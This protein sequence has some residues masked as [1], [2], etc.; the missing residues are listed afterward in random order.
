MYTPLDPEF[1]PKNLKNRIHF[2]GGAENDV[3][4]S[5]REDVTPEFYKI[6]GYD[7]PMDELDNLEAEP[8]SPKFEKISNTI[9]NLINTTE[10]CDFTSTN[11]VAK[12][13]EK[14]LRGFKKCTVPIFESFSDNHTR[15]FDNWV[16]SSRKCDYIDEFRNLNLHGLSNIDEIKW[17]IYPKC[18][19]EN[20]HVTLGVGH[21][22]QAELKLKKHQPNTKFYAVDPMIAINYDLVTEQLNGS[23]FA[24]ALA[25]ETRMQNFTVKEKT[26]YV[27]K[28]VATLD[29]GYFFENLLV[30]PKI[31]TLFLDIE[32]GENYF[33]EYFEK[34]GKFDEIG[35]QICQFNIEFHN[36]KYEYQDR[37]YAFLGKIIDDERNE[38]QYL[39]CSGFINNSSSAIENYVNSGRMKLG[40]GRVTINFSMDCES[41]IERVK[42]NETFENELKNPV[43]FIRN[44]YT[45]YEFQEMLLT[46]IYHPSNT[47]CY[48]IDQKSEKTGIFENLAQLSRCLP[49]IILNPITYDF[50]SDGYFQDRANFKCLELI[51][52]RKWEHVIFLQNNDLVIK[53][54]EELAE[55]SEILKAKSL[56]AVQEPFEDRW[57]HEADWTPK[58]LKLFKN[59]SKV[60]REILEKPLRIWKGFNQVIL[61]RIFVESIFEMLDLEGILELFNQKEMYGVD[62]MLVQTLYRNN[63]GLAGQ[64]TSSNLNTTIEDRITRWS[65]W[66]YQPSGYNEMCRSKL[67]R[68][69]ICIMGVEY[70]AD[71]RESSFVIA[72]KILEDFD[73]APLFCIREVFRERKNIYKKEEIWRKGTSKL[74]LNEI[75]KNQE[76]LK[77]HMGLNMRF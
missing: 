17:L 61:S 20:I 2:N 23:F 1:Q 15:F 34:N 11:F 57:I 63:L 27:L 38:L 36:V 53:S 73:L 5:L 75:L 12:N 50:N 21:D 16:N 4:N 48:S 3:E 29:I 40:S 47:Y 66:I 64:P 60:P 71:F 74:I 25:N 26:G 72:N 58:G 49:N 10:I 8:E 68:H 77:I 30:L 31:D 44:V 46:S 6:Y 7:G 39:D 56:M 70:L 76:F 43:A 33:L 52:A 42:N 35:M 62:E 65:D 69:N 55:L 14:I 37:I 13:S 32:G 59:E 18:Q 45:T 24:F 9:H 41:I 19:E 22:V 28:P 51:L 54:V 67:L